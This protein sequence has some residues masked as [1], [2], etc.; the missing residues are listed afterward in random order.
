MFTLKKTLKALF[1]RRESN[2]DRMADDLAYLRARMPEIESRAAFQAEDAALLKSYRT[3]CAAF[4]ALLNDPYDLDSGV[5]RAYLR[6][7]NTRTETALAQSHGL[8][9]SLLNQTLALGRTRTQSRH[10]KD[11]NVLLDFRLN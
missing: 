8:T 2:L 6:S 11:L 5:Y 7:A 1:N 10:L 3:Y 9:A 4:K